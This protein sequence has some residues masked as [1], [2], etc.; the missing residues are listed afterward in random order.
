MDDTSEALDPWLTD[1]QGEAGQE[2]VSGGG[3]G[4]F[5]IWFRFD[6]GETVPFSR[7]WGMIEWFSARNCINSP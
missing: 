4:G 5:S 1:R 2:P 7:P 3:S 6:L